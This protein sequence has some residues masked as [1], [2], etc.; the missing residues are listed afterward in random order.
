MILLG[1]RIKGRGRG[2]RVGSVDALSE[3]EGVSPE[4]EVEHQ[5]SQETAFENT[6]NEENQKGNNRHG[7]AGLFSWV[8]NLIDDRREIVTDD[9]RAENGFSLME[10]VVSVVLVSILA[11]IAF[12]S[13]I[14]GSAEAN[15]YA[16]EAYEGV[17]NA[18]EM[19]RNLHDAVRGSH[20]YMIAGA[21]NTEL[22]IEN[23]EGICETWFILGENYEA[24]VMMGHNAENFNRNNGDKVALANNVRNETHGE[25]AASNIYRT[26]DIDPS[27]N[28][29]DY[30]NNSHSNG[31][32]INMDGTD[33]NIASRASASMESNCW[34]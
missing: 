23:S 6:M 1:T 29:F 25:I 18:E 24:M 4:V 26:P 3:A 16:N 11:G 31:I 12:A 14:T 13:M 27:G 15:T 19:T 34:S 9:T 5:T 30:I 33:T 17:N 21:D 2:N 7:N 10:M 8:N 28:M 20:A 32:T 22:R